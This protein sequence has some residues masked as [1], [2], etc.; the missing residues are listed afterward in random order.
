[1]Q[2]TNRMLVYGQADDVTG[3]TSPAQNGKL[4]TTLNNRMSPAD[5]SFSLS[6]IR[7]TY[8]IHSDAQALADYLTTIANTPG[9]SNSTN[10]ALKALYHQFTHT[11]SHGS[12]QMAGSATNVK[13]YVKALKDILENNTDVLSDQS[14]IKECMAAKI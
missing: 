6:S 7:N 9:W 8:D 3:K 5:I 11:D 1:M 12:G 10:G 13:A 14:L 2:G 4:E